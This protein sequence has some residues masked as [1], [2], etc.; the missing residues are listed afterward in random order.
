M[1]IIE[2]SKKILNYLLS[3]TSGLTFCF[4]RSIFERIF[5]KQKRSLFYRDKQYL[6]K[7]PEFRKIYF[8]DK[9]RTR[10]Y[11]KGYI[12]RLKSLEKMYLLDNI[13][14]EHGDVVVDCGANIGEIK[15]IFDLKKIRVKY[16]GFEPGTKEFFCLKKNIKEG[17]L[18]NQGLWHTN[19]KMSFFEKTDTADSSFIENNKYTSI[20]KKKVVRLDNYKFKKIKLL[21]VEAEGAEPEVLIGARKLFKKIEFISVDCGPERGFLMQKTDK[22]V[23]NYLKQNNYKLINKSK[24]RDILLFRNI[25]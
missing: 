15:L 8:P 7:F 21:K 19:Q 20:V 16:Y 14:Y 25:S 6:R 9:E 2:Y 17:I 13:K 10:L 5:Y 1:I 3:K 22:I 23:S 24:L 4:V 18:Y 12:Y 11:S